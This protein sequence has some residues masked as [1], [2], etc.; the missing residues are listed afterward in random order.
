MTTKLY[1]PSNGTEGEIFMAE[2]CYQCEHDDGESLF[3][4][5]I[6][7]SMGYDV[8]DSEYPQEWQYAD[9]GNTPV[10]TKFKARAK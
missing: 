5:L 3:C 6:A 4:D 9:D 2:F 8:N 1:R 10:C 7:R